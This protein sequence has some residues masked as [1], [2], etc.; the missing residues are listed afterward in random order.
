MTKST[1]PRV[2]ACACLAALLGAC[3][4]VGVGG[5]VPLIPRV[6]IGVGMGSGGVNVGVSAGR[7]PVSAGVGVNQSGRVSGSAGLG[8][9][10][11]V[12][13]ARVGVGV[14]TGVVLH[15]PNE[16]N[17]RDRALAR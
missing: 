5:S 7:G 15:D 9:S 6:A 16:P 13:G 1:L 8:V 10:K 3:S 4:S 11:R 17:L 2:L 14:G 12:G